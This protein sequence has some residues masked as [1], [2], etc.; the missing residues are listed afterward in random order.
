MRNLYDEGTT[1]FLKDKEKLAKRLRNCLILLT[2]L[3]AMHSANAQL[4]T[5][6][7]ANAQSLAQ[8]LAG[9]GVTISNCTRSGNSNSTGTFT[10]TG[11]NL[12]VSGGVMLSTG[13]VATVAQAANINSSSSYSGNGDAQLQTLTNGYIYDKTVLEFDVVPEGNVLMFNY[14]FASEEY[15]EWVCTQFND[16]F[17]FFIS[18]PKPGGGNYSHVNIAKVPNSNLPVAINTINRGLSGAY[19]NP[20]NCQSLAYASLHRNNLTP[21][22]NTGIVF[23]GMTVVLTAVASVTPCQTYH[24]KLAIGDIS[25][26]IYDSG[27]FL[28]ANSVVSIPVDITAST[29]LQS[30]G[31]S[32][33]YEGCVSGKFT[34]SLPAPQPADV[35]FNIQVSGTATNG[36]DYPSIP[37]VITI[38]A[39]AIS[40]D[41]IIVPTQDGV[42]EAGE[43]IIVSTANA[44]TGQP[45]ASAMLVVKDDVPATVTANPST[46]CAGQTTQLMATGGLSYTW[47]PAADLSNTGIANPVATPSATTTYTVSM[48][49]GS[50]V[51]TATQTITVGGTQVSLAAAPALVSCDGSPV[52]LTANAGSGATFVWSGGANGSSISAGNTGSYG[53]TATDASGCSTTASANV[54]V[55]NLFLGSSVI[56]PSCGGAANG[57]VDIAV[58]GVGT[59]YT[60][61]WSNASTNEDLTSVAAGNYTVSVQNT[62]GC[63]V[64]QAYAVSQSNS[65][66][67]IA[68]TVT[69]VTCNGGNNGSINLTING[70]N[71]PYNFVWN[72]GA[73]TQNINGLNAGTYDVIVT[74]AIG[75][76]GAESV[77]VNELNGVQITATKTDV[78]CNG[79]N[80][81]AI[82]VAVTGGNSVYTFNWND[83]NNNQNR[84]SLS[85]GSYVLTVTDGNGCSAV[86]TTTIAEPGAMQI[87][88]NTTGTS[89]TTATGSISTS[90][91]NGVAPF[92][93]NWSH[94]ANVHTAN[95]SALAP[96]I[97]TVT[98]S[99]ANGCS[100]L[101]TTNVGVAANTAN[102]NFT[103]S[104]NYCTGNVNFVSTAPGSGTHVWNFGSSN[105]STQFHPTFSFQGAGAYNVMHIVTKGFCV[106]TV[107]KTVNVNAIPSITATVNNI[108][109]NNTNDGSIQVSV[110][111][112]SGTYT[113]NWGSG[114]NTPNRTNLTAGNYTVTVVDQNSCS[115]SYS[116][117]V[118]Q[119]TGLNITEMHNNIS[120]YGNANGSISLTIGGG[121]GPYTYNWSNGASSKN[122]T[123]LNAGTFTVSV[124]DANNCSS[125]KTVV[126]AQPSEIVIN[127]TH[128][129]VTCNG[130]S[131]GSI[132]T[133]VSGGTGT[134]DYDWSNGIANANVS[135]LPAGYY[136]V[137]VTDG[138]NCSTISNVTIDQPIALSLTPVKTNPLCNGLNEGAID[139]GVYGGTQPY[140]FVWNTGST[141]QNISSLAGGTYD[142]IVT[143]ANGC[144]A[145]ASITLAQPTAITV[146]EAHSTIGCMAGTKGS[147][148]LTVSGGQGSYMYNWNNGNQTAT[149]SNLSAGSYSVTV[150]DANGCAT[151]LNNIV[152]AENPGLNLDAA[153]TDAACTGISNGKI[154]LNVSGGN[155]PYLFNWNTG[156]TAP[157]L[158]DLCAGTYQVSV[159]DSKGCSGNTTATV[160]TKAGLEL[161]AAVTQPTCTSTKGAI[162]LSVSNGTAPYTFEWS[163]GVSSEDQ[164][165]I[166]D[167][168]YSVVVRDANQCQVTSSFAIA[169]PMAFTIEASTAN[170]TINMG[171]TAELHVSTTSTEQL[172]YTWLPMSGEACATC[173]DV[174]VTPAQTTEYTVV[175][176]NNS[177]CSAT[178][179]VTVEVNEEASV[180]MPNAF[181]PNG[182]GNN[183][184]LQLFG[185]LN[186][187]HYFQ[188]LVFNRWGEKVYETND[189]HF[190]WDGT[191]RGEQTAGSYIYVMKVVYANGKS[192]RTF[193]G[194]ITLL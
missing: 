3:T 96:A 141:N 120:C 76:M 34:F 52:Q 2:S 165:N 27:V 88:M 1:G 98:V 7:N 42:A 47:A 179:K 29:Q 19:G 135:S 194:S 101:Q 30:N 83:A 134:Y 111:G 32:S 82:N 188:L 158:S 21:T 38:P 128:V 130:Q 159:T 89:C 166:A 22:V 151:Q 180:W 123:S 145:Q 170:T 12:G 186:A 41:L 152:I 81:G 53:V 121:V 58:N 51:K 75:C 163:N 10:N 70:G 137:T 110:T 184:E 129:D 131:N 87:T 193:K 148:S 105:T 125:T 20:A 11:T 90:V 169:N 45:L 86:S 79:G 147:I 140:S 85:A 91:A 189:Q 69:D 161:D 23:D 49:W 77:T 31:D 55:S 62:D 71:A 66:I 108:S 142:V 112:G 150:T 50:C 162:N 9:P 174:K 181:T 84:S 155:A 103:Q 154:N 106:D 139:A 18:G 6:Q 143:D 114:I 176:T 182:D 104:G 36:V 67:N 94:N 178:G 116:A 15:P 132:Q 16:V 93:Y 97:I 168:N 73:P 64:T 37:S 39:G 113:Y 65:S 183:D 122:I 43:T 164:L 28:E 119:S 149:A 157:Y 44:C 4:V 117:A 107:V 100:T 185:N 46:L 25:D 133:M 63:L 138:N 102:A 173:T 156:N 115:A 61:N 60:F 187:I 80:N 72:N 48:D 124:S 92:T 167:G 54:V 127:H 68:S 5:T 8:T 57:G 146:Q 74:D 59:P 191:Y 56:A 33:A 17:G 126:I 40:K 144:G 172:T 78:A 175:A 136:T 14:V 95:V 118:V 26:R 160:K 153:V 177:G 13:N 99:D 190:G 35:Q 24:L 171:E 192:D 109:C